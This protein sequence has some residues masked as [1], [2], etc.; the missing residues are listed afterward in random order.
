MSRPGR[1]EHPAA[2]RCGT[3]RAGPYTVESGRESYVRAHIPGAGFADIPGAL[4]DPASPFAFTLP[5]AEHF[6]AAAG[7]L[8]VGGGTHVVAYAQ[9]TPM[10]RRGCG[11]CCATSGTMTPACSTAGLP[12]GGQQTAR[13]SRGRARIRPRRSPPAP[14]PELLASL[15]DLREITEN[16]SAC[17][18]NAL[19][20]PSVPRR[21]P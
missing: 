12:P 19:S 5:S 16:G 7:R 21:G 8:G 17:L 9:H 18:V 2:S 4:S 14:G 13:S 1:P 10:W 6:A 15:A 3:G 11:G 20:P